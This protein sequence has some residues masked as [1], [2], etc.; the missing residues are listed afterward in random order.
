VEVVAVVVVVT[1]VAVDVT[2]GVVV[3]M[4]RSTVVEVRGTEAL[5]GGT[6]RVGNPIV[7]LRVVKGATVVVDFTGSLVVFS[8]VGCVDAVPNVRGVV[9][10]VACEEVDG[11]FVLDVAMIVVV[12]VLTPRDITN[13]LVTLR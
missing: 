2:T 4:C 10:V 12:V 3:V 1:G 8:V 7:S 11:R 6:L 13:T 9:C 5:N